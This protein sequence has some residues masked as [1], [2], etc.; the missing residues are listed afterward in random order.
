[1]SI[2]HSYDA[3]HPIGRL[4]GKFVDYVQIKD[5][6]EG[7]VFFHRFTDGNRSPWFR[8]DADPTVRNPI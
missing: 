4:R 7:D 3:A 6:K 2:L 1:M 8:A 5:L